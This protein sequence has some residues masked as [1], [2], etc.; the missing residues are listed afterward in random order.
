[1]LLSFRSEDRLGYFSFPGSRS[2]EKSGIGAGRPVEAVTTPSVPSKRRW[3]ELPSGLGAVWSM[4]PRLAPAR[5]SLPAGP[6]SYWG[7]VTQTCRPCRYCGDP[8]PGLLALSRGWESSRRWFRPAGGG[9]ESQQEPGRVCPGSGPA[10]SARAEAEAACGG[11]S[12]IPRNGMGVQTGVS[13]PSL[14]SVDVD[15]LSSSY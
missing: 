11:V 10:G 15:R 1:M 4:T 8:R 13:L 7:G 12:G 6:H 5:R 9:R 14:G 2:L 3:R